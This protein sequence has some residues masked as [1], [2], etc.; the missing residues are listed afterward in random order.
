MFKKLFRKLCPKHDN[1]HSMSQV[2]QSDYDQVKLKW[3]HTLVKSGQSLLNKPDQESHVLDYFN[4][5]DQVRTMEQHINNVQYDL[6]RWIKEGKVTKELSDQLMTLKLK[7]TIAILF[8]LKVNRL[9]GTAPTD[10][11]HD[12]TESDRVHGATEF[13][14]H[15]L[16]FGLCFVPEGDWKDGREN[17][18]EIGSI[19]SDCDNVDDCCIVMWKDAHSR[20]E[21]I[22]EPS[23]NPWKWAQSD[24]E[25]KEVCSR[26]INASFKGVQQSLEEHQQNGDSKNNKIMSLRLISFCLEDIQWVMERLLLNTKYKQLRAQLIKA[27]LST[28][29]LKVDKIQRKHKI[30]SKS[31]LQVIRDCLWNA[32]LLSKAAKIQQ[33]RSK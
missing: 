25:F 33:L 30:A 13:K 31:A 21:L 16:L 27:N 12:D 8:T 4:F 10:H 18:W 6:P 11:V 14:D 26:E 2:Q 20:G 19:N 28:A 32:Q 5:R 1:S 3:L 24:E 15:F 7:L 9:G 17:H 23:T 29:Q 22:M